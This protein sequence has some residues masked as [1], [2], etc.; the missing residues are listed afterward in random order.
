M[1]LVWELRAYFRQAA[2]QLVIGSLC[3]IVMVELEAAG[4]D[5]RAEQ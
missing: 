1:N 4:W 2:G 5:W 3:G